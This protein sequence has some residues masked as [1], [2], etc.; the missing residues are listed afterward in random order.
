MD[1]SQYKVLR[2]IKSAKLYEY[3]ADPE[4]KREIIRYL[5]DQGYIAYKSDSQTHKPRYCYIREKGKD[6]LYDWKMIHRHRRLPLVISLFAAIGGY[7]QELAWLI[8]AAVS[9]W[10]SIMG[11]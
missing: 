4:E 6:A 10:R 5:G 9:L 2:E 1:R 7:R 11:D 8:Q 3:L